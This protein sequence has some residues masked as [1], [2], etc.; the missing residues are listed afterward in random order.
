MKLL[1]CILTGSLFSFTS[2]SSVIDNDTLALDTTEYVEIGNILQ[3]IKTE[4]SDTANPILLFLHGGPGRTYMGATE[5]FSDSLIEEFIFVQWDQRKTGKTLDTNSVDDPLSVEQ[6]QNDCEQLVLYLLKKYNRKKLFLVS[7]SWGSVLGFDLAKKHPE[8]VHAYI[9]ISPIIDQV[10]A[11][12]LTVKMLKKWAKKENNTVALK[13][14]NAIDIPLETKL[15]LF[16][17]QRWLFI[18]NGV[19]FAKRADF[20]DVYFEWMDMWF[21]L[22]NSSVQTDQFTLTPELKCPLFLF[23]GIG[24]KQKSHYLVKRY[25]KSVKAP[26]KEFVWFKESGHTVFNTEPLKLQMEIIAAKKKVLE[27]IK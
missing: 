15:D 13:E 27:A 14:L 22:W 24:D 12:Q 8:L 11:T 1:I 25:Y 21:P 20:R 3:F 17:Q 2:F 6:M 19:D 7:H 16:Y 10:K 23:E 9:S 26:M 18:Y 5:T 4:A